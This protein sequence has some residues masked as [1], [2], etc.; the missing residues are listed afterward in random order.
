MVEG[1]AIKWSRHAF[2]LDEWEKDELRKT[3]TLR[4]NYIGLTREVDHDTLALPVDSDKFADTTGSAS[5]D[6]S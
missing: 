2:E 1:F 5:Q 3:G 6:N 4:S